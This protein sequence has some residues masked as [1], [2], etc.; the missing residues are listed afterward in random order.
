MKQVRKNKGDLYYWSLCFISDSA[1]CA[2]TPNCLPGWVGW[3]RMIGDGCLG[4]PLGEKGG[5][6][7]RV[8]GFSGAEDETE[9]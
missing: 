8:G 5:E 4:F 2:L 6:Y 7:V 1:L 3:V 9:K